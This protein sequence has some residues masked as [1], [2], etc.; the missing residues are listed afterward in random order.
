MRG[1]G[2]FERADEAGDDEVADAHADGSGDEDGFAAEFID[3][4]DG[5]DG[6]EEF[7]YAYYTCGEETCCVAVEAEA[8]EDEG[9]AGEYN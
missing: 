9:G 8:I 6:E 2:S 5:G 4:E 1:P 7:D 3:V